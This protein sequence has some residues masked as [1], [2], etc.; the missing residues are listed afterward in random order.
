MATGGSGDLLAGIIASFIA[1]GMSAGSA[2]RAAV[3]VHGLTGDITSKRLSKRGLTAE[4]C[5]EDLPAVMA[6]FE[7]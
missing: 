1:Q 4:A 7:Y 2:A 5:L 6:R 3:Y